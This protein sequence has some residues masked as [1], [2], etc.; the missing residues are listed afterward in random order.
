MAG[1]LPSRQL[2]PVSILLPVVLFVLGPDTIRP[3]VVR[4]EIVRL[5]IPHYARFASI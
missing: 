5:I 2:R 4:T 3:T 1:G